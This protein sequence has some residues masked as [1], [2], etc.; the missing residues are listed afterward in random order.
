MTQGSGLSLSGQ[1]RPACPS[2]HEHTELQ[3]TYPSTTWIDPGSKAYLGVHLVCNNAIFLK[4][5]KKNKT[6]PPN[7]SNM[8]SIAQSFD[9][10][11][12]IKCFLFKA[13]YKKNKINKQQTKD[14]YRLGEKKGISKQKQPRA[15]WMCLAEWCPILPTEVPMLPGTVLLIY[16][17]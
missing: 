4:Q 9:T 17:P 10:E 11:P 6:N 14:N 7:K 2:V 3:W 5:K 8:I 15:T 12:S 1:G 13:N 16:F